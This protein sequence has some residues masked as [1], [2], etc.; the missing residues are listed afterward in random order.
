[1]K[2]KR[3]EYTAQFYK[4][5][6][7]AFAAALLS[8]LLTSAL[9][10]YIAWVLQQMIDAVS[11]VP[12]SFALSALLWF[13]LSV[14]AAIILLK[15]ASYFSKPCFMEKAMKQYKNYAFCKLTRKSISAFGAENTANYISAFSND[16]ATIENSYLDAQF[17]ILFSLVMLLGALIMMI[18]YSPMMTVVA[19]LFF[20]LPI[21]A[22]YITGNRIEKAERKISEKNSEL[23]ATLKDSLSGFAVI[24][25]F[26][27]ETAIFKIFSKNN[28]E[29]EQA[30]CEKRKQVTVVSTLAGAAGV[31]A[32]L[33]TFL[34]GA[35]L[36]LSGRG[37][38]P[39]VLILFVD[40]TAYVITPIRELP[41]Q[42][43]SRKAAA[44]LIDKLADS[45]EDHVRD[46][47]SLVPK[48]LNCGI[49]LEHM[50][51]GYEVGCDILHD[52]NTTFDAGK[53]Y[54]IVGAS[55]SG[56][57]TLLRLMARFWDYQMGHIRMEKRDIREIRTDSLLA[58]ISM[59]MQNAYLFHGSLREN[60]CFGNET[61]SEERMVEACRRACCHEFISALPEGYDTMVGEGGATLSGGERQRIS[62]ARAFLKDVPILLLDEPT[63]SL[64][65]DNEAMVQRA[66]DEI[67][68][69]RTVVMIAHRLKTVRGAEQILVLEDG[70]IIEQGTH[71]Q[72]VGENG[73][74]ARLWGLQNQAGA[75]TFQSSKEEK[76]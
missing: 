71:D 50:T 62:L 49:T 33:G 41:E 7:I 30:K 69:E 23:T 59:V 47:G 63:A 22:S 11:G 35:W 19:C 39:G 36:A 17:N 21:G 64:D 38:T 42:L 76:K 28:A 9:N 44:A 40:L 12:G 25:S 10:L 5:N 4:K 54:A 27:A 68:R 31:T 57:S 60:L 14:I 34:V 65:A 51:F 53:K 52:I 26:R 55:G 37:I 1:M 20:V 70:K 13:V 29:V 2:N 8:S 45:L 6:H 43:A 3:R 46:E 75:Y 24:K 61:I 73:L 16:A 48:Q 72:L 58:Q 15:T 67:A 66:L 56:K 74:Y 18:A 32:Q